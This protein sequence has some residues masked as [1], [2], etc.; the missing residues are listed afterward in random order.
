M[1]EYRR[2]D[3]YPSPESSCGGPGLEDELFLVPVVVVDVGSVEVLDHLVG[4]GAG[5]DGLEDSEGDEGTAIFI[6]QA[7]DVDDEGDAGEGFGEQE[8]IDANLPDV[9]P[10]AN[11]EGGG[12][13]L[14]RGT[15][16]DVREL[17]GNVADAGAPVCDA[18][19]AGAEV[20]SLRC[21][22]PTFVMRARMRVL[23]S[24][25]APCCVTCTAFMSSP[26]PSSACG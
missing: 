16:V 4:A 13:R 25:P 19:L 26:S 12:G 20:T 17:E 6:V 18:Q 15:G 23:P 5:F 22:L 21:S 1:P 2:K 7:V 3:F 24:T 8:G 11:T 9:V 14:P 10:S